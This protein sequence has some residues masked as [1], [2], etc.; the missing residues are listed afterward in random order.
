[1]LDGYVMAFAHD[2]AIAEVVRDPK[3][4][5]RRII[6]LVCVVVNTQTGRWGEW[7]L[8]LVGFGVAVNLHSG[9]VNGDAG[10]GS[11]LAGLDAEGVAKPGVPSAAHLGRLV[12]VTV[13]RESGLVFQ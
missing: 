13:E 5:T 2:S 1:M 8:C 3:H 9:Q 11:E 7:E 6:R 4:S 10:E 12:D